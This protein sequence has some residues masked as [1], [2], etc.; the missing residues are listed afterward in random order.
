MLGRECLDVGALGDVG[1]E[2][3]GV[4]ATI[5]GFD[6]AEGGHYGRPNAEDRRLEGGLKIGSAVTVE[7]DNTVG[8]RAF[9]DEGIVLKELGRDS[10]NPV[11]K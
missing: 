7:Q 10:Q 9:E 2:A 8:L 1:S 4:G 11:G 3:F 5:P 6:A